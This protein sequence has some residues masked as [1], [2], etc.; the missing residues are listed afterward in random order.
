MTDMIGSE[1]RPNPP[2]DTRKVLFHVRGRP[3]HRP[4]TPKGYFTD[5]TAGYAI[6]PLV[7]LFGLN[8]VDELDRSAFGV[9]A[10]EIRDNLVSTTNSSSRS[11]R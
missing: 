11:S 7:V 4:R 3:V 6:F 8:A 5:A 1:L 9:L 10:P 2:D